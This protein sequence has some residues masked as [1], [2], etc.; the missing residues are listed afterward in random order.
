MSNVEL[1]ALWLQTMLPRL[2]LSILP[3]LSASCPVVELPCSADE[4]ELAILLRPGRQLAHARTRSC[5]ANRQLSE[6]GAGVTW[7]ASL[8]LASHWCS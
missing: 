3:S 2:R 5:S 6:K 1:G 8:E 7:M 4:T